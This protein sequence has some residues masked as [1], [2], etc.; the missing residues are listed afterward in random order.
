VSVLF[1]RIEVA[2][3]QRPFFDLIF[4]FRSSFRSLFS[5]MS[6]HDHSTR[7]KAK[8]KQHPLTLD[9]RR[10]I[11][12]MYK[13]EHIG[14]TEITRRMNA[15]G[16]CVKKRT[17]E[18]LITQIRCTGTIEPKHK[19]GCPEER[20]TPEEVVKRIVELAEEESERTAYLIQ[21]E[22][23]EEFKDHPLYITPALS[24]IYDIL[25]REKITMKVLRNRPVGYNSD[26]TKQARWLYV[27][28]FAKPLLTPDNVVFVDETPFAS[29]H[30]RTKGWSCKGT[31][32]FR[33]TST[34]RGNNHSV[35][36][37]MS[38]TEGLIHYRIKRTEEDEQYQT[39]GVGEQVFKEFTRDLLNKPMF[40]ERGAFYFCVMDNVNFHKSPS[41]INLYNRR[42]HHHLLPPYSPFLNPIEFVFAK[43]KSIFKRLKHRNDDE[44]AAA[45]KESAEQVAADK[46][47]Y[48]RV[49]NHTR[50]YY[51]RVLNLETIED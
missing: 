28:D 44:V 50:K 12:H 5:S 16:E 20:K 35:I 23:N 43:W 25:K 48:L 13:T 10:Q 26:A 40:K 1:F 29:H 2:G 4:A 14:G 3:A 39:K 41:I 6:H 36:A 32:A 18:R 47:L 42:H 19:G 21:A 8:R 46:R 49:F 24:T 34:A 38:P 51:D 30:H 9:E 15:V 22:L 37:A 17:V 33:S 27:H 11:E 45:I 31:P 7:L